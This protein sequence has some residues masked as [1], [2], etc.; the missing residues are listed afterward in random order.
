MNY[1]EETIK[2]LSDL[3]FNGKKAASIMDISYSLFSSR[4]RNEN[5]NKFDED[6]YNALVSYLKKYVKELA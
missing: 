1:H 4:K 3:Q 6:N 2:I 5:Y